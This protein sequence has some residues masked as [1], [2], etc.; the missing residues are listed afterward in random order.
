MAFPGKFVHAI[1]TEGIC[2]V[3]AEYRMRSGATLTITCSTGACEITAKLA[4]Y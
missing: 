4:K 2:Y 3:T 1:P